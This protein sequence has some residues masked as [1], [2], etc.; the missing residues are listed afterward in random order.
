MQ[1]RTRFHR[2]RRTCFAT[3]SRVGCLLSWSFALAFAAW[4]TT[5]AADLA[6][7]G[8]NRF[9]M[10]G[11]RMTVPIT[12][13]GNAPALAQI[14]LD[15]GD[16]NRSGSLPFMIDKPLLRLEPGR[17]GTVEIYYQGDGLPADRES[18]VLLNVLDVPEAP[19]NNNVLQIALRHRFKLLYRPKLKQTTD[20]AIAELT[21]E[22]QGQGTPLRADNPS[23]YYLTLSDIEIIG[24]DGQSCGKPIE[25]LMLPPF[26][27]HIFD[28]VTCSA[29]SLR[30][31]LVSDGGN[32]RPYQTPLAAGNKR[33]GV[34]QP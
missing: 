3:I 9:I 2:L 27:H 25:H 14:S 26:S 30:Y 8:Q 11:S 6:F 21:W 17:T 28:T 33:H 10:K 15:W 22:L 13:Q 34:L 31:R 4:P 29:D 19:R 1:S 5:A 7:N 18:Y 12:N 32:M 20:E 23:P 24:T 16:A